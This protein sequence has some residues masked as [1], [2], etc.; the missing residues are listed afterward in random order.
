[1]DPEPD[2]L[3]DFLNV[4]FYTIRYIYNKKNSFDDTTVKKV[5][6]LL[7]QN[8]NHGIFSKK[9]HFEDFKD[10][11]KFDNLHEVLPK[12]KQQK[13]VQGHL[14]NGHSLKKLI[15]W[16]MNRGPRQ[17]VLIDLKKV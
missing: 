12:Q 13:E 15:Q 14:D 11:I 17:L 6:S 16:L 5:R 10:N 8:S 4:A 2:D 7:F 3:N 9:E 1:M